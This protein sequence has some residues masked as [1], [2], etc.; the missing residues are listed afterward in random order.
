MPKAKP[1][2]VI[3]HR[4]ELQETERATLEAAL[5]GRFVSNSV[6]AAGN[7]LSGI[8]AALAPFS[9]AIQALAILWIADRTMDEILDAARE[10]GEKIKAQH[11]EEY[12]TQAGKHLEYFSAWLTAQYSTDGWPSICNIEHAQEYLIGQPNGVMLP[13]GVNFQPPFFVSRCVAFLNYVCADGFDPMG[14]TPAEL[15]AA[16]YTIEEYGRD[17]YYY[18]SGGTAAG[19]IWHTLKSVPKGPLGKALP[20]KWT[21]TGQG[22]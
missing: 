10:S 15:W 18:A 14:Q 11:E 16:W 5:A 22:W 3:V 12:H 13:L 4:I 20:K 7:V 1:D 8:G 2:Q 6:S 9:G 19:G 17:A 21:P